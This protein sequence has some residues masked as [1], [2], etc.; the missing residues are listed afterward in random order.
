MAKSKEKK[1]LKKR[2]LHKYRLLILNEDTFEER[3]SFKLTRLNVFIVV[4]FSVIIFN[5]INHF[6]YCVHTASRIYS[7]VFFG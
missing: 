5:R 6:A 4:G 3:V 2:L 7:R 1:K